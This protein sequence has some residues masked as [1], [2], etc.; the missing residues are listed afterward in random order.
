[1]SSNQPCL[2]PSTSFS[3]LTCAVIQLPIGSEENFAGV[4]DLVTM[5]AVIWSGEEMGAK[6]DRFPVDEAPIDDDLKER[7]HEYRAEL[8]D[9]LADQDEEVCFQ[10]TICLRYA[11]GFCL[12]RGGVFSIFDCS[13]MKTIFKRCMC[14]RPPFWGGQEHTPKHDIQCL[15]PGKFI[16]PGEIIIL[17]G[18]RSAVLGL[19]AP[20]WAKLVRRGVNI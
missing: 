5:E 4:V 1:M 14:Q 13:I 12:L 15:T 11:L 20:W 17:I 8:L 16:M 19:F 3:P 7:A 10:F 2:C 9:L 6:F 18:P